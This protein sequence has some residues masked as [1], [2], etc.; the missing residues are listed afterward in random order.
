MTVDIHPRAFKNMLESNQNNVWRQRIKPHLFLK[1]IGTSLFI[2]VFFI[3]YLY[4]LKHPFFHVTIV[5]LT[6]IDRLVGFHPSAL[7]LYASLWFYVGIP[8]LLL[9]NRRVLIAYGWAIAWLCLLGLAIFL[10]LPTAVP[11]TH[12]DWTRYPGFGFLKNIDAA[13]NACPSL[14]VATAVFSAIWLD[15]LL[16]KMNWHFITRVLNWCWCIGIVYSTLATKQHVAIDALFGTALGVSGAVFSIRWIV[17][18]I[19]AEL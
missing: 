12:I 15:L 16:C 19:D 3:A 6:T 8:P 7:V 18:T 11:P 13:G 10:F 4:L 1:L 2:T 5:P 9:K 17:A 14:H